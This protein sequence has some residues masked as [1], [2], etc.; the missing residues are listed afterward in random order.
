MPKKQ[1]PADLITLRRFQDRK[2][3]RGSLV[4]WLRFLGVAAFFIILSRLPGPHSMQPLQ[5]DLRWIGFAMSLTI[6]G[7][8]L[9]AFVWHW[10]LSVQ[11]INHPYPKSL[12]AYLA[13]QYLGLVTP[14]HVGEFL[15]AGYV[16][17]NT[18]ITFGYGLS[19]V[20]MKKLLAWITIVLFGIWGLPLLAE[21]PFFQGVGKV[22]WMLVGVVCILAAGIGL[23]VFSIRR[24][25][26]KWERLSPWQ[27][28]MTEF[29]AGLRALRS[30][31]LV[32]PLI[33]SAVAFSL[34]FIQLNAILRALGI[35]MP[36]IIVAKIMAI[37]RVAARLVPISIVGFGSKDAALIALLTQQGIELPVAVATALLL[38]MTSYLV[39]LL[40]SGICWW[41]KPLVV[42]KESFARR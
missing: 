13:S 40:L 37:S 17:M 25:T 38:L 5:M 22:I 41:V 16:S 3:I 28:D 1:D 36:F 21:V 18:G 6:A 30:K 11:R 31:R 14:G 9:E 10:L 27:V 23:W 12:Q 39:T 34:L 33:L 32:I 35:L 29:K 7:L 42:R 15:A 8:L 24:L 19:S 26:R 20:V 2:P 4:W